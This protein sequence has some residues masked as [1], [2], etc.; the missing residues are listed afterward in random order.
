[1]RVDLNA[2]QWTDNH[3]HALTHIQIEREHAYLQITIADNVKY[4][5]QFK[6][7]DKTVLWTKT[8]HITNLYNST[9]HNALAKSDQQ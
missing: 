7:P 1:M 6:I 8:N 9:Q 2:K 5:N 3:T 4:N